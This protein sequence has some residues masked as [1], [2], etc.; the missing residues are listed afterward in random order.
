MRANP[1]VPNWKRSF[2]LLAAA[3]AA[4]A[5]S[6]LMLAIA[7]LVRLTMG[8]PVL[9]RQQRPGIGGRPFT[10]YKFRSMRAANEN[11][12]PDS[13]RITAFGDFLRRTSLDELPEL[14]N[15][16]CGDMSLVGP[17]PLLM[18][19][20]DRY[21]PEQRRRLDALPGIT[22]WA[23]I[24]GR[25]DTTWDERLA[26]DVWYVDHQSS[27]L[28]FKIICISFAHVLARRGINQP[29][30]ATMPEFV[31]SAELED[32]DGTGHSRSRIGIQ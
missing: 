25:N 7:L 29:G 5:A 31:G 18:E 30:H 9:F 2:D 4:L 17:R 20:L 15:V 10:I 21:T 11:Q 23:Q 8:K 32:Q 1:L 28:D 26:F 14:W 6:P 16:I 12:T 3:V 27:W 19:Y 24:H 22:G 13:Q